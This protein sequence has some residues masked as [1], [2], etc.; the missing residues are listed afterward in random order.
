M[1]S[2][3][4]PAFNAGEFLPHAV[5]SVLA[6]TCGDWELIL[7]DDGS[8]DDTP[9]ICDSAAAAD[10]RV[11]AVHKPNGG[12][13]DARNAGLEQASGEWI[14]FLDAD[15]ALSPRALESMLSAARAAKA[16]I[17]C[18]DF[19]RS[20]Q[21]IPP[22]KWRPRYAAAT[23]SGREAVRRM[24]YQKGLNHSAWGKLYSRQVWGE[25]RF[26]RGTWFE[27]LDL[28]YRVFLRAGR[29]A[30]L[31]EPLYLYRENPGSFLHRFTPARADVLEVCDRMCRAM[32]SETPELL[33]AARD[34]RLAAA[35]NI[36]CLLSAN[37][38][39]KS[40]SYSGVRR[41]CE[42]IIRSTRRESLAD[43]EVRLRN[44]TGILA[45]YAGGF[46]LVARMAGIVYRK[47]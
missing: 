29:V 33:R 41:R 46:G 18:A 26:R 35:F 17:V 42:E 23:L 8:A 3:V 37:G 24:L 31:P 39:L 44:K 32:E 30:A 7:V 19:Y 27:D 5:E 22:R 13:S 4:V 10:T 16:D 25:E 36:F 15:D 11:K 45:T 2:I 12:L 38:L 14:C 20:A 43:P 28:F 9:Q 6:Q 47:G 1:I 34:R 21:A 40:P